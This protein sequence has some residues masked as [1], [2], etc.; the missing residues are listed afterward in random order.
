MSAFE[1]TKEWPKSAEQQLQMA[2]HDATIADQL[3]AL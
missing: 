2:G 1:L 3:C